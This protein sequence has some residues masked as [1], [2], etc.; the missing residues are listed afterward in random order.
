[1]KMQSPLFKNVWKFPP[2]TGMSL[3]WVGRPAEGAKI[4]ES[5]TTRVMSTREPRS[6][7]NPPTGAFRHQKFQRWGRI[8]ISPHLLDGVVTDRCDL[9]KGI[10]F[11]V[12]VGQ[13]HIEEGGDRAGGEM[14]G[15]HRN[16]F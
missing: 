5:E 2:G 4:E 7:R 11:R 9:L 1:M 3:L 16:P 12:C 15:R 8:R 14:Q 6:V 10:S 13:G